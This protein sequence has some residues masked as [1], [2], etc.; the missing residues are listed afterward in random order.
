MILHQRDSKNKFAAAAHSYQAQ[1]PGRRRSRS[2]PQTIP[3]IVS[4]LVESN[5]FL[6]TDNEYIYLGNIHTR[7]LVVSTT[8][9]GKAAGCTG[10]TIHAASFSFLTLSAGGSST[11][12]GLTS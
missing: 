9:I 6:V 4:A 1:S 11:A 8:A 5:P 7:V 3:L 10:E 2:A 12:K